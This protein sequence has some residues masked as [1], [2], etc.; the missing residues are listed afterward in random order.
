MYNFADDNTK[1]ALSKSKDTLLMTIGNEPEKEI[2]WFILDNMIVNLEKFQLM[3][4]QKSGKAETFTVQLD[5]KIIETKNSVE[6][7]GIN[8]DEKLTCGVQISGLC[9]KVFMQL[10]AI[11]RLKRYVG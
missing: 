3:S 2:D 8:I 6:L 7:L 9:N 10:N 4:L 5:R 11:R 1:S